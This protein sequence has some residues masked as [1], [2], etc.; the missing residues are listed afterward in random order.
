MPAKTEDR[1]IDF[2]ALA[3][4]FPEQDWE[5]RVQRSG[6]KNGR[7][8]AIVVPYITNRAIQQRLDEVC[9]PAN[10]ENRFD[11][12]EG[13]FI[14]RLGI[15][16]DDSWIWKEDGAPQTDIESIKGGLSNAMKRAAVQWGMGRH[17]YE[18]DQTLFAEIHEKGSHSD[19]I[20]GTWYKWD[21]PRIGDSR[22]DAGKPPETTRTVVL[23][24]VVALL[25]EHSDELSAK[26]SQWF[27][28]VLDQP[29]NYE[30]GVIAQAIDKARRQIKGEE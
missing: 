5:W 11:P 21:P 7:P 12:I 19:K 15:L 30:M 20:E 23:G 2:E 6:V 10:W 17:L 27:R 25:D 8:W 3:A 4:P 18:I 14:C 22:S 26:A 24:Q 9:G 1:A 28:D 13:G 29:D 16:V